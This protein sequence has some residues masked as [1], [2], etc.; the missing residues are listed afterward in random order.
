MPKSL[1]A[2]FKMV[3]TR[4]GKVTELDLVEI[5][6]Q[7]ADLAEDPVLNEAS[8]LA[9]E[10]AG[11][12]RELLMWGVIKAG[13][14]VSYSNGSSRSAVNTVFTPNLQRGI[15]RSLKS[16]RAKYITQMLSSS[17]NYGTEAVHSAFVAVGHTD[18]DYD[19]R[20]NAAFVPIEKY[21]TMKPLHE[22]EIG[23]IEDCRYILSP[24]LEPYA[25]A[26]ASGGTNVVETSS[27]ADVYPIVYLSKNSF[28]AVPLKGAKSMD[29]AVIQPGQRTKSDPLGQRGYVSWK[30]YFAA[31]ILNEAWIQRA[32][33][34]VT[35]LS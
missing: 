30:M 15:T 32:E 10:Q 33:V 21:G 20:T 25:G 5:S 12:T 6:D 26:G 17:P 16:Q 23:K 34:A 2:T 19:I 24:V 18:L 35:D 31:V 9:G 11:E 7:V 1:P 8:M 4:E 27:N 22:M 29:P 13:T 14:S 3:S 28:A